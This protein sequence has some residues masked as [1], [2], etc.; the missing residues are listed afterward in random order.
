MNPNL[1]ARQ[2]RPVYPARQA[3][4]QADATIDKDFYTYVEDFTA[5]TS[6]STDS[7]NVQIQ[8]DSDFALQKL[9]YHA[10]IARAAQTDSTRVIPLVTLQIIDTGSGRNLFESAVLIPSI[11]GTGELPF[12]LPTPRIFAA[13]STVT[14]NVANISAATDY[15]VSLYLVGYKIFRQG[16]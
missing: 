3:M 12:I 14:L 16:M 9:T 1:Y 5:L 8:A 11:M 7:G 6:G 10:D 4:G 15:N 13:R 2:Q